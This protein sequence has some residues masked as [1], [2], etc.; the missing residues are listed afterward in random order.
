MSNRTILRGIPT[1]L[2]CA[3]LAILIGRTP[4]GQGLDDWFSD[5][6][7]VLRG[8]RTTSAKI[9]IISIDEASLA[10]LD[11]PAAYVSPEL[12]TAI[13]YAYGQGA[14]AIGLDYFVPASLSKRKAIADPQPNDPES[15]QGDGFQVAY[16]AIETKCV[17]L[18][19]FFESHS[20]EMRRPL[21]QWE[22]AT[23][24]DVSPTPYGL[25]NLTTDPDLFVRRQMLALDPAAAVP[26]YFALAMYARSQA[27][28]AIR[29]GNQVRVADRRIPLDDRGRLTI[30]FVGPA[31]TPSFPTIPLWEVLAANRERRNIPELA[32]AIVIIGA[33]GAGQQDIH[34]TPYANGAARLFSNAALVLT[35]GPEIHAH[36][37]ATIHDEA[38]LTR[39][40]WLEPLPWAL[41]AGVGLGATFARV[42]LSRGAAVLAAFL[43]VLFVAAYALFR[44]PGW[45]LNPVPVAVTALTTYTAV[46]A[47]RWWQLRRIFAIVKSEAVT[48]ALE[49]DPRRLDPGG[50][51][52]EITALFADIRGFTTFSENCGGNPKRVVALLNAY[53]T[54]VIPAIEAEGG[55]IIAFMGDG[56]M[57]LFGAPVSQTDHAARAVRAALAMRQAV[58]NHTRLWEQHQFAGLRIGVGVHT[59]PAV[60]G[61]VG[62]GTRKDY[63]AIGDTINTASRVEGE[64]KH[65]SADM[66]ITAAT[67]SHLDS[68]PLLA[69][70]CS[71]IPEPVTLKGRKEPV[72]LFQIA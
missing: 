33:S 47:R 13:R 63:T 61:A 34:P 37:I 50:E 64:T 16:A 22:M 36:T 27:A 4:F 6:C 39:P 17:V 38:Y 9:A 51:L 2:V 18:P 43:S 57:V 21:S 3:V 41:L 26:K 7:F 30:N 5:A 56:L 42:S 11:K 19:A 55:T 8:P 54:A 23:V 66:L 31:G 49:A 48:R 10:R 71:L 59:G 12:A 24:H 29:D 14:T 40:F 1:G 20:L 32:G 70:R 58:R 67:R 45:L 69:A 28:S 25:L 53:Y 65:Q 46:L 52:R 60:V 62:S 44:F 72:Q 35:P 68:E 15:E